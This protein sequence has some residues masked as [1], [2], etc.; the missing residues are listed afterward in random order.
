MFLPVLAS[1]WILVNTMLVASMG[2][3]STQNRNTLPLI[4]VSQEFRVNTVR[5]PVS[6]YGHEAA[7]SCYVNSGPLLM[8]L[9]MPWPFNGPISYSVRVPCL[10]AERV[11]LGI[12]WSSWSEEVMNSGR[13]Q[14]LCFWSTFYRPSSVPQRRVDVFKA[15][16]LQFYA[17]CRGLHCV[18]M[19][20][21]WLKHLLQNQFHYLFRNV[22]SPSLVFILVIVSSQIIF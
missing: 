2:R 5:I 6:W 21:Q 18:L 7:L 10:V 12:Q 13:G 20:S 8:V 11:F 19:V 9:T 22:D 1:V 14:W 17:C 16:F 3:L 15:S 4:G